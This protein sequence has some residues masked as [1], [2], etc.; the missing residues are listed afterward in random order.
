[1]ATVPADS[2]ACPLGLKI[3]Q[4]S[5]YSWLPVKTIRFYCDQGLI[6]PA[7]RSEGGY[8]LFD[9][10]VYTEL[11]L[12]RTLRTMEVPLPEL[13]RILEVRRSG[14]CNCSALKGSIESKM[15]AIE[16]RIKD[17]GEMRAEFRKLLDDWQECGGVKSD[18][19][20]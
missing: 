18:E 19:T 14:L 13:R 3:G 15:I 8:R 17:L 11:S 20:P 2:S 12:I 5:D 10:S 4:V 7:K 16:Q 6:S 1:M 9:E